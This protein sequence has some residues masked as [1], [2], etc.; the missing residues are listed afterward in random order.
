M[1][2]NPHCKKHP[3]QKL[4]IL[5]GARGLKFVGCKKCQEEKAKPK[6]ET[7]PPAAPSQPPPAPPAPK[8]QP[9]RVRG[10]FFDQVEKQ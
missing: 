6:G 7:K 9:K 10:I 3:D 8:P 2:D 5:S 4:E 1:P